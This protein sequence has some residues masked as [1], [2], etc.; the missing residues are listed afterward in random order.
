MSRTGSV[1]ETT[2]PTGR[3]RGQLVLVAGVALALALVPLVFAYLQLGYHEDVTGASG[4]DP[5]EQVDR[6]LTEAVHD[7]ATDIP[8]TYQW[9]AR[10]LA[11][12]TVREGLDDRF[13][14]VETARLADGIA[15]ELALNHTRAIEW[16]TDNCPVGPDRQFGECSVDE[17]V[18]MQ[19]RGGDVHVLGVGL[20]VRVT[21]PE[22]Q[23][24]LETVVPVPVE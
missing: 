6:T 4:M 20:D 2:P 18:V 9:G 21:G 16:E 1:P 22:G 19:D 5:L 23:A 24:R 3:G 17:G 12:Q 10:D 13:E 15:I 7:V 14:D 8:S 11:A